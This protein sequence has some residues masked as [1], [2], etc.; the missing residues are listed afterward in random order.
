MKSKEINHRGLNWIV[1]Y[2]NPQHR[3]DGI[4]PY[5]ANR[6][7]TVLKGNKMTRVLAADRL[8][9]DLI[10]PLRHAGLVIFVDAT[11]DELKNGWIWTE[12]KPEIKNLPFLT[13][14]VKPAFILGLLQSIYNN[15]PPT[16]LVS[17]QGDDFG[18]GG[19]LT[20]SAE[21]RSIHVL[22]EIIEF[23]FSKNI[24]K[25]MKSVSI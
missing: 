3:D 15:C 25:P 17:V 20:R 22:N 16:W 5:V 4:G 1:G 9:P 21:E 19:D 2:G 14:H 10:M 6:A 8:E 24:D 12:I 7:K 18:F 11:M 13:Y 23:I